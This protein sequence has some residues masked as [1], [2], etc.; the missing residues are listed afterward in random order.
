MPEIQTRK[1]QISR[2]NFIRNEENKTGI[3]NY[4]SK[5]PDDSYIKNKQKQLNEDKKDA[6]SENNVSED[7][8]NNLENTKNS[9]SPISN[10]LFNIRY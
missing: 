2:F 9:N 8:L 10:L 5:K 3:I 1:P 7:F 4:E 6:I